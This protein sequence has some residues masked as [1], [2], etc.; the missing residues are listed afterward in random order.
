MSRSRFKIEGR[1]DGT[2][3]A[4]VTIDRGAMLFS[5]RPLRRRREYTLP[6][7]DVAEMVLWRIVKAEAAAKLE[8]KRKKRKG[9]L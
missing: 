9:L 5:V 3:G 8:L 4:T 2:T 1:F 6:L 7:T